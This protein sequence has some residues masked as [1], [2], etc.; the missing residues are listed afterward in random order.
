MLVLNNLIVLFYK[1]FFFYIP[2]PN[3]PP[4]QPPREDSREQWVRV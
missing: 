2:F 1:I 3:Y 4:P